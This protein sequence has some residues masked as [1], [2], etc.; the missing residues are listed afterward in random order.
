MEIILTKKQFGYISEQLYGKP[1]Q[2]IENPFDFGRIWGKAKNV[3]SAGLNL[4]KKH[5]SFKEK[6]YNCPS[7]KKTIGYGTRIDLHPELNGKK[8]SDDV[9]TAYLKKDIDSTVVPTIKNNVKVPL[10]QNQFNAL[11]SLIY[12]IGRSNFLNSDLLKV[13]NSKNTKDIKKNWSEFQ[14]GGG[15]VLPGLVKR[16]EEEIN[17]FFTK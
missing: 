16:R 6:P 5:E 12:N 14:L 4:I 10:N 15:K 11:A 8:I 13:I 7:G 3:S 9:A 2:E 17:L 1:P